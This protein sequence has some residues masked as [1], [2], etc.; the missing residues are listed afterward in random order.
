MAGFDKPVRGLYVDQSA[1]ELFNSYQQLETLLAAK[2][3]DDVGRHYDVG[4]RAHRIER[5]GPDVP[6]D[7]IVVQ[8]P[9]SCGPD[10]LCG[11]IK[12]NREKPARA[13]GCQQAVLTAADI[14]PG[15]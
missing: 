13:Q 11:R 2:V 3:L 4:P 6:A 12:A 5:K 10:A 14:E 7:V 15:A 9:V 1:R 8:T